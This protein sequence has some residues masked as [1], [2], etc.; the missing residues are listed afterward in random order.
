MVTESPW[1]DESH[2]IYRVPRSHWHAQLSN[3]DWTPLRPLSLRKAV[4]EFYTATIAGRAPH[5]ILT[6]NP[7]ICKT[8]IGIGMYRA[9]ASALGTEQAIWISVPEFCEAVKRG[10]GSEGGDVW[11]E[12]E[13]ATRLVVLDDLF[14]REL[15]NHEKDQIFTRLI[16]GAYTRGAAVLATMNPS[17]TELM[18]RLPPHEISRLLASATIVPVT[19]SRDWRR[20]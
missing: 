11:S 5:L 2:I 1:P 17:H 12:Y 8:H 13:A 15:T 20:S 19:S 4:E 7:G 16:D 14:G 9:I 10:Y 6:G 3:I 18:Q